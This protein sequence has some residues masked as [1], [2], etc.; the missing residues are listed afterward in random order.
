MVILHIQ[1]TSN[2]NIP[3]ESLKQE[4]FHLFLYKSIMGIY[5]VHKACSTDRKVPGYLQT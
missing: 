1:T 4:N 2:Y 5:S 3:Y